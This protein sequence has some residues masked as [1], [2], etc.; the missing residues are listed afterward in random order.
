MFRV[1]VVR[2][3]VLLPVV[4]AASFAGLLVEAGRA[5]PRHAVPERE[6]HAVLAVAAGCPALLWAV[7]RS[8][9]L[10]I[11]IPGG[12]VMEL[13]ILTSTAL[14]ATACATTATAV[15]PIQSA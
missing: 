8:L 1:V 6:A 10:A 3:L 9:V 13:L 14:G 15:I 5:T 4:A 2:R 11:K 12:A 7:A